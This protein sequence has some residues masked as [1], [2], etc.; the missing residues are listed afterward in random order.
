MF[1]EKVKI[2]F[3]GLLSTWAD[4]ATSLMCSKYPELQETNPRANPFVETIT[5]LGVQ[6]GIIYGGQKLKVKPKVTAALAL[7]PTILPFA[8]A[9][10]NLALI[11]VIEARTYPWK[12]C[13][14]LY[15]GK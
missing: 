8:A 10:K 6:G 14:F 5:V 11:A 4:A 3:I 15:S 1:M 9:T 7:A 12:T 13:P 2:L